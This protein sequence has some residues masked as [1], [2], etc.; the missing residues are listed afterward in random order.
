MRASSFLHK[1]TSSA[2]SIVTIASFL[3]QTTFS[4]YAQ[5]ITVDPN[6]GAHN[7]PSVTAARN[8][9]PIVN[10]AKPNAS[11]LSH[12]KYLDFNVGQQ[13]VVLNNSRTIGTSQ[14]GGAML[15][16]PNLGSGPEANL[17]LNEVTSANPSL[18]EG[19]TEVF[20]GNAQYILANPN[21]ITCNGCGFIGT[22]RASLTTGTPELDPATGALTGLSV[23]RGQI[24]IEGLGL[25]AS[26][27]DFFDIISRGVAINGAIHGQ[28]VS[29]ITGRNHVDYANRVVRSVKADDGSAK[30]EFSV[31]SSALGGMYANRISLQGTEAGVGVRTPENLSTGSGGLVLTADGKLVMRKVKSKGAIRARSNSAG[32]EV[33][34]NLHAGTTLDLEGATSLTVVEHATLGALKKNVKL[35]AGTSLEVKG[36]TVA[37]GV[38]ESGDFVSGQGDLTLNSSG[39]LSI[40][41]GTALHAGNALTAT[42]SGASDVS[43]TVTAGN[44]VKLTAGTLLGLNAGLIGAGATAS[45]SFISGQGDVE[46]Q[47]LD[48]ISVASGA[49]V[50]GGNSVTSSSAGQTDVS[51]S[52]SAGQAVTLTAGAFMALGGSLIGAGVD[53]N[54][55]FVT[56]EGDVEINSSG[57][58][59][60]AS[61]AQVHAGNS[62]GTTSATN[63]EIAGKVTS[64]QSVSV[65]AGTS[66]TTVADSLITSRAG[67]IDITAHDW[68]N[69]GKVSAAHDTRI[70]LSGNGTNNAAISA[71]RDLTLALGGNFTNLDALLSG[72]NMAIHGTT[73]ADRAGIVTNQV[74]HIEA[75]EGTLAIRALEFHNIGTA[76]TVSVSE[77]SNTERVFS[78][79]VKGSTK[80]WY[81]WDVFTTDISTDTLDQEGASAK[82]ASGGDLTI[83]ADTIRNSYSDITSG[84]DMVLTGTTLLNEGLELTKTTT[85]HHVRSLYKGST[86]RRDDFISQTSTSESIDSVPATISA[87]GSL[88]G[89]FTDRI[90]GEVIK[91]N[92]DISGSATT[93]DLPDIDP[94]GTAPN[95]DIRPSALNIIVPDPQAPYLFET[96]PLFV[97]LKYFYNSDRFLERFL[98]SRL[99][100]PKRLGDA[101]IE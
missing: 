57:G 53:T 38:T 23:D 20:G 51:G 34:G 9:V 31:D 29:I 32:V 7:Q 65:T 17:I 62:V 67:D 78:H 14:L 48:G 46:L 59:S 1:A 69:S 16:N 97:D 60:V 101:Y 45:G 90:D 3:L 2:V 89:T 40:A 54:G 91:Q 64:D 74:G 50:Y 61:N 49:Q 28:D 15:N 68:T 84:G 30:P 43:G 75:I 58:L 85:V 63:T 21:G 94:S 87:V 79:S 88:T 11:G 5:D 4:S 71:K 95:F 77:T 93:I 13:G 80:T 18:L 92:S 55:D 35:T 26:N 27:T 66:L 44:K 10:I 81:I 86:H 6:A 98:N 25:D 83:D 96:D 99:N 39:S 41:A 47:S 19:A 70:T 22:P 36:E 73:D 72:R 24:S 42:S 82:L 56:D 76:P 33:Q 8:G 37:A 100:H 12:N 52:V